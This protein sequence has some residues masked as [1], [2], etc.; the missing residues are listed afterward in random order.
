[1]NYELMIVAKT[2]KSD[3]L[4]NRVEKAI[5]EKD[6]KDL[7]VES[8][9]K[10]PL[11]YPIKKQTDANYYVLNFDASA[12]V[13]KPVSEM[14]RLE[15]EDLLRYLIIKKKEKIVKARQEAV[16]KKEEDEKTKPKVT[17]AVKGTAKVKSTKVKKGGK[18]SKVKS[19]K[20]KS[21]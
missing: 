14:L 4:I 20:G 3:L 13:I 9:G 12:D 2:D 5:K 10:K 19:T 21:K 11:A 18:S 16:S 6:A 7:K 1:M 8:L 17:V 15:Q